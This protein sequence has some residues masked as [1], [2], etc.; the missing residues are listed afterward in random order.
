MIRSVTTR[1]IC[2][3]C[4][5]PNPIGFDVPNEIWESAVP[6]R[7]RSG[8]VCIACFARLADEAMLRWDEN[9]KM[10]P[11]SMATHLGVSSSGFTP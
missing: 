4:F 2:K 9:I 10:Y 6:E 3:A 8:V 1:E 7:L 5:H 11:V